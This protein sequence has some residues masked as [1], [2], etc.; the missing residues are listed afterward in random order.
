MDCIVAHY[1]VKSLNQKKVSNKIKQSYNKPYQCNR[2][3]QFF[4]WCV[5]HM[6]NY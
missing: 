3:G 6:N 2:C 1:M 5:C 4:Y